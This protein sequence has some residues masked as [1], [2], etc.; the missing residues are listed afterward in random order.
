LLTPGGPSATI[1]GVADRRELLAV[2]AGGCIGAVARAALSDEITHAPDAW[3]WATFVVNL[4]G[5]FVLGYV[6]TRLGDR[7]H[8]RRLFIGT[9]FCGALTTFSTLQLETLRMLDVHA[10]VLAGAY[11]TASVVLGLACVAVASRLARRT[12]LA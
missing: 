1:S 7:H 11:V 10:Y 9:G 2:C 8:H 12:R 5:A 3:P 4:A 6:A